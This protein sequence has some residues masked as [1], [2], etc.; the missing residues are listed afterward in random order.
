MSGGGGIPVPAPVVSDGL[1]YL[2]SNH[3][4]IN[5]T[6]PEQPIFAVRANAA[7]VIA[8]P[9]VGS[10]DTPVAWVQK[11]RGS[12]M[13]TPL[14]YQGIVYVGKDNGVVGAY[15]ARTGEEKWRERVGDGAAGFTASPVA[16]DGKVYC[17][18]E[19]GDVHVLKAGPA[20]EKIGVGRLGES[21]LSTPAI[22]EG[23]FYF[24]TRGHLMSIGSADARPSDRA[25]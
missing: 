9:S 14:V 17:T 7:G 21:C 23:T 1:V 25:P 16:A 11:Q 8:T 18:S 2:T 24:H 3:R 22:S 6:D 12:Y 15:D 10:A 5:P 20:F 13:Q 4:P 19:P